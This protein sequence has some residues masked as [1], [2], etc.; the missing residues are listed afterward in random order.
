M[1]ECILSGLSCTFSNVHRWVTT[2]TNYF[3][4]I[5]KYFSEAYGV[6]ISLQLRS[7]DID[8]PVLCVHY[9]TKRRETLAMVKCL[10]AKR[11]E[12]TLSTGI[13]GIRSKM[14]GGK[15]VVR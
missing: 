1:F 10:N 6:T 7:G 14:Q 13:P 4:T 9:L 2:D 8:A 15:K 5:Y 12:R 3:A 11:A